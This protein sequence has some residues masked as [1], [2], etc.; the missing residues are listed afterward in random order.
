MVF[1]YLLLEKQNTCESYYVR[2]RHSNVDCFYLAQSYFK[3]PRQT[4]RENAN[5]VCL[6]SQDLKNLNHI[7]DDHVTSD[8]TKEEF[9]QLCKTAWEKQ[10]GFVIIDISSKKNTK[11]NIEVGLTS[12]TYQINHTNII[13]FSLQNGKCF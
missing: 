1:D 12:F 7:F 2:G 8:M 11:V 9:R 4:I 5:F 10:H 3:L 13:I 6:F